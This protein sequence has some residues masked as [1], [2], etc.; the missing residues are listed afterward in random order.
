MLE[1]LPVIGSNISSVPTT[2]TTVDTASLLQNT[3][4][5]ISAFV[6]ALGGINWSS[7]KI[8]Y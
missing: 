4:F 3:A 7:Y 1:A 2:V 6:T 5:A 8:L